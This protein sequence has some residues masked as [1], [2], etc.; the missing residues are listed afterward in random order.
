M[1]KVIIVTTKA[2]PY[3]PPAKTLWREL[4]KEYDFE[5]EEV[6]ATTDRGQELAKQF[7]IR[8]VPT[9]IIDDKVAFIGV[10][11]KEKAIEAV[12]GE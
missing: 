1:V 11:P 10:P 8:M 7:N 4:K 9:T 6:D 3:C 2:C 12:K 5:Y